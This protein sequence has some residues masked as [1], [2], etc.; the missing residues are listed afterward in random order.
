MQR[1]SKRRKT[2]VFL[3]RGAVIAALYT[4]LT[5]LVL[6][7]AGG[8]IQFR[9]SE[10]LC[11]LPLF[12]PEAIVGLWVGCIISNILVG[13]IVV[14]IIFGSVATLIG[15][16]GA[17]LLRNLPEKLK[18]A[19]TMPTVIANTLI[20]PPIIVYAYGSGESLPFVMLTVGI[21]ELLS[22]GILGS[23]LYYAM[24]KSKIF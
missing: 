3:T 4:T 7:L 13:G 17:Y 2:V 20:V 12:F 16:L 19:A 5:Y 11:I 24:R 15:A 22:A 10:M 8:V 1:N 6:P 14:D 21:G 9:I 18:W 23:I